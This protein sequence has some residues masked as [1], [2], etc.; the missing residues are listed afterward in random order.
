MRCGKAKAKLA[1]IAGN[2]EGLRGRIV[3]Q[4]NLLTGARA[5]LL[6]LR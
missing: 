6:T 2:I 1:E 5:E 4:R 3:V